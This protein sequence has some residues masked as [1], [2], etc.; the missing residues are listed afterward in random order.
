MAPDSHARRRQCCPLIDPIG[1]KADPSHDTHMGPV[2]AGFRE[3]EAIDG[4][5][6]P[7]CNCYL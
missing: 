2:R 6:I 1:T 5:H 7:I 4:Q 3:A